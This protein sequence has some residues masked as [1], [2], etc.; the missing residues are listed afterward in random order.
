MWAFFKEDFEVEENGPKPLR[1]STIV[2]NLIRGKSSLSAQESD[3][4]A[5]SA[6]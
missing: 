5:I 4:N 2:I 6:E 1:L 3:A